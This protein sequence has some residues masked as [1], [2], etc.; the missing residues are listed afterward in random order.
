MDYLFKVVGMLK[1]CA[2][3]LPDICEQ[4]HYFFEA[5]SVFNEKDVSNRWKAGVPEMMTGIAQYFES[6]RG[7]WESVQVKETFSV[8]VTD[9]GWCFGVV[10]N[11]F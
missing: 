1:E 9:K 10:M 6:N 5:P 7:E 8:F 4:D 3:F 11:A 2:P